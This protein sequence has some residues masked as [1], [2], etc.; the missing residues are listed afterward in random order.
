[1]QEGGRLLI[2]VFD[3]P[4]GLAHGASATIVA[5]FAAVSGAAG[6]IANLWRYYKEW[7]AGR[8]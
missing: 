2:R 1:M 8:R 5:G 6:V 7:S 4:P 3:V